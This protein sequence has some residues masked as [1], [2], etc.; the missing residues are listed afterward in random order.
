MSPGLVTSSPFHKRCLRLLISL[1]LDAAS[2][3]F[4]CLQEKRNR[5]IV[6]QIALTRKCSGILVQSGRSVRDESGALA[7]N[8]IIFMPA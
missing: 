5:S 2:H 1:C 7:Q 8:P 3:G 6:A 4:S